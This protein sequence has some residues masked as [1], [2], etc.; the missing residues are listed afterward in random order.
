MSI[1][2]NISGVFIFN[3]ISKL[4]NVTYIILIIRSLS[5]NEY[6]LFTNFQ[7]IFGFVSTFL[8]TGLNLILVSEIANSV[9]SRQNKDE[10][11]L[12]SLFTQ[13]FL[14]LIL[15]ILFWIFS[16]EISNIF[17][18][19]PRFNEAIKLGALASLGIIL[20]NFVL[21]IHQSNQD[22]KGINILNFIRPLFVLIPILILYFVNNLNFYTTAVSFLFGNLIFGFIVFI[23][24]FKNL[25][26]K[27]FDFWSYNDFFKSIYSARFF[28]F[29]FIFLSFAQQMDVFMLSRYGS[30]VN[31]ANYGVALRYFSMALLLLGSINLVILPTIANTEIQFDKS[32]QKVFMLKWFNK[33]LWILI[34]CVIYPLFKPVFILINGNEYE[35]AFSILWVLLLTFCLGVILSPAINI[36]II[37]GE[38]KL[39]FYIGLISCI[40]SIVGNYIILN[41]TNLNALG[42]SFITL[43]TNLSIN[44]LAFYRIVTRKHSYVKVK[45]Q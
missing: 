20:N 1:K 38:N 19:N 18:G 11:I 16:S 12:K 26:I 30:D 8:F 22:F 27:Y 13:I 43:L 25:K 39:M 14:Y 6:S 29:Y 5:S 34:I 15:L 23:L 31:L 7:A 33:S 40:I 41:Y 2:K 32:K 28:L 9:R 45:R 17:F 4:I 36:L 42:V 44:G 24:W 3:I 35:Y 37:N 10:I 21:S